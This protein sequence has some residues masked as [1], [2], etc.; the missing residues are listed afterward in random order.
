[1]PTGEFVLQDGDEIYVIPYTKDGRTKNYETTFDGVVN[2]I[3]RRVDEGAGDYYDE[4]FY[5]VD[6]PECL[7]RSLKKETLS[8]T[9][10]GKNI[11][12]V[13]DLSI[14]D[15]IGFFSNLK[16]TENLA[17]TKQELEE[18]DKIAL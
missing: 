14:T 11:S 17:F 8:I 12:E 13:C 16:M 18:I 4:F 3:L 7:G 1:M 6:C 5:E 2:I 9:V 10:G 15:S